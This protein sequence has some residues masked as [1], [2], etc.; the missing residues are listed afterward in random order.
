MPAARETFRSWF[1]RP[2]FLAMLA[3]V[4]SASILMAGSL[5]VAIHQVEQNESQ[6][7]NA[8][9]ERFLARLE[10]LFG[11]LIG[12]DEVLLLVVKTA[13]VYRPDF[14]RYPFFGRIRRHKVV[15]QPNKI[16]RGANPGYGGNHV[17]P[18]HQH[19]GPFEEVGVHSIQLSGVKKGGMRRQGSARDR[20]EADEKFVAPAQA[21]Q[22]YVATRVSIK[23]PAGRS[24]KRHHFSARRHQKGRDA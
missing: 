19:A 12:G 7:M 15:V 11:Q 13:A 21:A 22:A 6:E 17:Q 20:V 3:A 10:Q 16:K 24:A 4:L 18:A 1:Y 2:W 9:G 8:Q 14:S 23:P 5:F